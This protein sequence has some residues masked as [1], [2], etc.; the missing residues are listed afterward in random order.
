MLKLA[1]LVCVYEKAYFINCM[2]M[3]ERFV[4]LEPE[5]L[6]KTMTTNS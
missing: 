1:V 3:Y 5:M 6:K 4:I 2:Y